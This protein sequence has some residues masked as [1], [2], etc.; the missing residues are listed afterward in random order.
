MPE[1]INGGDTNISISMT[2]SGL[3]AV[4]AAGK[5]SQELNNILK[6]TSAT[7]LQINKMGGVIGTNV[8]GPISQTTEQY[9][10]M[11]AAMQKVG[12]TMNEHA[13]SARQI[14]THQKILS[15]A[16]QKTGMIGRATAASIKSLTTSGA[17]GFTNLASKTDILRMRMTA[18]HGD[19]LETSAR[20]RSLAQN[21][22]WVGRQMMVGISLPLMLFGQ[23][24]ISAFRALESE[25]VRLK[26]VYF[27][28]NDSIEKQARV[29]D[30]QLAPAID[31][32]SRKYA[33]SRQITTALM[34]DWAQFG[35]T[36]KKELK[37]LTDIT[38]RFALLGDI[39]LSAATP[40]VRSIF[41][42]F[43]EHDI[44]KTVHA[45]E[46]MNAI[47]NAT[48]LST[49]DL[50]ESLPE[51]AAVA[52]SLRIPIED[53]ASDLA[54]MVNVGIP[55][56]EAVHGLKF[57]LQRLA[58]PTAAAEEVMNTLGISMFNADG[59]ARNISEVLT[60][61]GLDLKNADDKTRSYAMTQIFG[62]RQASRMGSMLADLAKNA[63]GARSAFG[64]AQKAAKG[65]VASIAEKEMEALQASAGFKLTQLHNRFKMFMEDMG[66]A[67]ADPLIFIMKSLQKMLDYFDSLG[68]VFKRVVAVFL[69]IAAAI[70]PVTYAFAQMKLALSTLIHLGA[71][72]IPTFQ[73]VS[74]ELAEAALASGRFHGKL[75]Q[76]GDAF[77]TNKKNLESYLASTLDFETIS[78]RSVQN[79]E[80]G[81]VGVVN[82]TTAS[83]IATRRVND[84][85]NEEEALTARILSNMRDSN[86]VMRYP[87]GMPGA[88]NRLGP[89]VDAEDVASLAAQRELAARDFQIAL[90]GVS[91]AEREVAANMV[92]TTD[93]VESQV[94]PFRRAGR[95]LFSAIAAPFKGIAKVIFY[96]FA[97][98][99]RLFFKKTVDN[100]IGDTEGLRNKF[101]KLGHAIGSSISAKSRGTGDMLRHP[102]KI[103]D[104]MIDKGRALMGILADGTT[105]VAGAVASFGTTLA[106]ALT[107]LY[108][109]VPIIIAMGAAFI[110]IKRNWKAME[111]SVRPGIEALKRGWNSLLDSLERIGTILLSTVADGAGATEDAGSTWQK[112][113]RG[114]S[115]VLEAIG[116]GL[117]AL[118]DWLEDQQ[119]TWRRTSGIAIYALEAIKSAMAGDW[120]DAFSNLTGSF[121]HAFIVP[122]SEAL[123]FMIQMLVDGLQGI[124]GAIGDALLELSNQAQSGN[125]DPTNIGDW[126]TPM[127]SVFSQ[128]GNNLESA[129][130]RGAGNGVHA[131]EDGLGD[132]DIPNPI[133]NWVTDRWPV[134][135][136]GGQKDIPGDFLKAGEEA[137]DAFNEGLEDP[138]GGGPDASESADEWLSTWLGAVESSLNEVINTLKEQAMEALNKKFEADLK[139]Y[140]DRIAAI[141]AVEKA[142]EKRFARE[143]YLQ[144]RRE[145][146]RSR[147]IQF[148][149]YSRDRALAIYE[150]RIDD[151]RMLDLE[152]KRNKYDHLKSMADLEETR[153]RELI[154]QARDE[155]KERIQIAKD[156][157]KE[158][159][160]LL[161]E[162]FEKQLEI[163]T[164]Y[165]PRTIAEFQTMLDRISGALWSAGVNDWPGAARTGMG[166]Y[167]LAIRN[168]NETLRQQAAWS[169]DNAATAW[170]AAFVAGDV[171]AGLQAAKATSPPDIPDLRGN[172]N[173]NRPGGGSGTWGSGSTAATNQPGFH[174]TGGKIPGISKRDVPAT[175]QTGEFV[176]Q[177]D[178]VKALGSGTLEQLNQAHVVAPKFHA[179]GFVGPDADPARQISSGMTEFVHTLTNAWM[180]NQT[181][182]GGLTSGLVAYFF[183]NFGATVGG[184]TLADVMP[185]GSYSNI[186]E[187]AR[188]II[189]LPQFSGLSYGGTPDTGG[190]ARPQN[191][192]SDHPRGFAA[193]FSRGWGNSF[194][195]ML[196]SLA[197]FLLAGGEAGTL[198]TKY[199]IYFDR[200]GASYTGW[201][202]DPPV[203]SYDRHLDHVHLSVLDS[204]A[205]FG[206]RAAAAAGSGGGGGP[207]GTSGYDG[208]AGDLRA[209]AR[210]ALAQKGFTPNQ[211]GSLNNLIREESSWNPNAQNPDSTAYGLYQF[212]DS[213]WAGTGYQKTSDP[214]IQ[215]L[216]G[217]TYI[218]AVYDNPGNAWRMWQSRYPHWYHD[219]GLVSMMAGG[220]V[221]FDNYPA[222]LHKGEI[223]MPEPMSANLTRMADNDAIMGTT[224]NIHADTFVG[225]FDYF[226][227][228]M[229]RYDVQVKPKKALAAGTSVRRVSSRGGV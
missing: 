91:D 89:N 56:N 8:G 189:S 82:E 72:F 78:K 15:A 117:A 111:S 40:Y 50:A 58:S 94:H 76:V 194:D 181:A 157:A 141:E 227:K 216:A 99:Y 214:W 95:S 221:P 169:G 43:G 63:E 83:E 33:Q 34:A 179:G 35:T 183:E 198:P 54:A 37:E 147:S 47:E 38:S 110:T 105:A 124:F 178:A 173:A 101:V 170:L 205:Q 107:A 69:V 161:R 133:A 90:S 11:N 119:D 220:K 80:E 223:V 163:I 145:M 191:P 64:D 213:T 144:R 121:M 175:L 203:R 16:L 199:V 210:E 162:S 130:V 138:P 65:N 155:E 20:M 92:K 6:Q 106:V 79:F 118:G 2:V 7:L 44:E 17:A 116:D 21:M 190:Q 120:G 166:L 52:M 27:D 77:L 202:L 103:L 88:G 184:K 186:D 225:D 75:I 81:L 139:V 209:M 142:E 113:G 100:I 207:G 174:H 61:L 201:D 71:K 176:I 180:Y 42:T 31:N 13:Q 143:E 122:A 57:G 98:G 41:A 18:L 196:E 97:L 149:N 62:A 150:G 104:S 68:P 123:I 222:R 158:R 14:V 85:L 49:A 185:T 23:K 164:K 160:D 224:V 112:I 140:D 22:Q 197:Q 156:A 66:A 102:S 215:H 73:I 152:E 228:Q 5:S 195:P 148:E 172:N 86:N 115:K 211:F 48:A 24:A 4:K 87:V 1:I 135:L 128:I 218:R 45:L 208:P 53:L 154:Q 74:Q 29:F 96:P 134:R 188:W 51:I 193:D 177:R 36:S 30:T 159:Q 187:F 136:T 153:R 28:A 9:K 3:E 32:T 167:A 26:K 114:I 25:Q 226:C 60:T 10:K 109:F 137:G 93:V 212:L 129:L 59:S 192:S 229:A 39:D 84:A 67:L 217:L 206:A 19:I 46:Q 168:A 219:G 126:F 125:F 127:H 108:V 12:N 165:A 151:A 200:F 55:A 146:L 204:I 70:G 182:I 171:K 132:I 131:L